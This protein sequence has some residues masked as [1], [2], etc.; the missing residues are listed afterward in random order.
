MKC[1]PFGNANN[2]Y[3]KVFN[4]YFKYQYIF[5]TGIQVGIKYISIIDV[6]CRDFEY[7]HLSALDMLQNIKL[8]LKTQYE[9]KFIRYIYDIMIMVYRQVVGNLLTY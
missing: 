3:L 2:G 9:Q 5:H 4:A 8:I 7:Y 6:N 1:K